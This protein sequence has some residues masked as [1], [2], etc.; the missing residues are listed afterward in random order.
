MKDN[1]KNLK[2]STVSFPWLLISCGYLAV[3][4][5]VITFIVYVGDKEDALHKNLRDKTKTLVELSTPGIKKSLL[6]GDDVAVLNY[7]QDIA[8]L[9][10]VVYARIIDGEGN[11]IA[12]D[13]VERW[14][15][16]ITDVDGDSASRLISIKDKPLFFKRQNP[17]AGYDYISP[18]VVMASSSK[19]QNTT[20]SVVGISTAAAVSYEPQPRDIRLLNVGVSSEKISQ[21]M[22]GTRANALYVSAGAVFGGAVV[23]YLT[24]YFVILSKIKKIQK[25]LESVLLG[26]I[27]E[28]IP[29]GD[30]IDE[31]SA[32]SE[33]VNKVLDK[34]ASNVES[35]RESEM[36][37]ERLINNFVKEIGSAVTDKGII[38]LDASDNIIYINDS[39]PNKKLLGSEMISAQDLKGKHIVD[40][41]RKQPLLL[42]A[43]KKSAIETGTT[44][45]QNLGDRI[46]VSITAIDNGKG[47]VGGTVIILE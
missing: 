18:L 39:A 5:L 34:V 1:M 25:S 15:K 2:R 40:V 8:R 35:M 19:G 27:S 36:T 20:T 14:G 17:P 38:V 11:I 44:I 9:P 4:V 33:L 13:K 22:A 16:K 46:S 32:V 30:S 37:G 47:Q 24:F 43:L 6:G 41:A 28:R 10:D 31:I 3:A 23:F 21:E 42:D 29:L 12:D 26:G 7:L 45:R